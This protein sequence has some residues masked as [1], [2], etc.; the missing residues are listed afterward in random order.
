MANPEQDNL[1]SSTDQHVDD[2]EETGTFVTDEPPRGDVPAH[3]SS[4]A[5]VNA[6]RANR[7]D[8]DRDDTEA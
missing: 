6:T 5:G 7:P 2:L 3:G 4:N 8:H 1:G